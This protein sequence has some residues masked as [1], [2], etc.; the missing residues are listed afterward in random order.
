M[1]RHWLSPETTFLM[2]IFFALFVALSFLITPHIHGAEKAFV[3]TYKAKNQWVHQQ[4]IRPLRNLIKAAKKSKT[5]HVKI[6]LPEKDRL[7]AIKRAEILR[8]VL[9]RHLKTDVLL[10]EVPGDA[11][12]NSIRVSL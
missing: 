4:D 10:E 1:V 5:G 7:L 9:L 8:D 2:K 3:L 12:T 6:Q 11:P